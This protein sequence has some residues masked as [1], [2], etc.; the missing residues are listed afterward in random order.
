MLGGNWITL[1]K[2][3]NVVGVRGVALIVRLSLGGTIVATEEDIVVSLR[4]RRRE[5]EMK[6]SFGGSVRCCGT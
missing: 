3:A 1:P 4:V 6:I 2:G 5:I